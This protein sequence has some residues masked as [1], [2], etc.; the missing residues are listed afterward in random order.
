MCGVHFSYASRKA[1][2][3]VWFKLA[4]GSFTALVGPNGSGKSTLLK[5]MCRLLEPTGG[6]VLVD[7]R[8]ISAM[9]VRS[10]ARLIG[11]VPQ[12]SPQKFDFTVEEVV[13]MG[14]NAHLGLFKREGPGDYRVAREAMAATGVLELADRLISELSG[15]EFQ[16]VLIARALAQQPS[17]LLL[18]EP[19]A[20]LDLRYQNEIMGLL[21][22]INRESG[23]TVIAAIH[24]LNLA[25]QHF[26]EFILMS[27]GKVYAAGST[28][29][30]ITRENLTAVYGDGVVVCTHPIYHWPIVTMN[31]DGTYDTGHR[32][33]TERQERICAAPGGAVG[34]PG[35]V[36]CH[37]NG[38]R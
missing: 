29:Q 10:V 36:L 15:G 30:V 23:I 1:L 14:R 13:L 7:G 9:S 33:S 27:N 6:A 38:D 32:R 25:T 37:G 12:E 4:P 28:E 35:S 8:S 34:R 11:V 2:D 19:T 17:A 31:G 18:D 3:G 5:C 21:K 16:R 22:K 26:K 24:D 20:H